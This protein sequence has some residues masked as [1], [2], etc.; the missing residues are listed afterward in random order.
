MFMKIQKLL[1]FLLFMSLLM[2]GCSNNSKL[3]VPSDKTVEAQKFYLKVLN[4]NYRNGY[5]NY[6]ESAARQAV[7][8]IYAVPCD[9]LTNK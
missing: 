6:A 8:T 4:Q 1:L 9:C 5:G 7:L 3:C 2:V